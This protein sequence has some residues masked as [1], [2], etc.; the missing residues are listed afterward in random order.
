MQE[1]WFR[2]VKGLQTSRPRGY[3]VLKIV[4]WMLIAVIAL[5]GLGFSYSSPLAL[6]RS[7]EAP[8]IPAVGE[9]NSG[10]VKLTKTVDQKLTNTETH[11]VESET[12]TI[13]F[14]KICKERLSQLRSVGG[15]S[16][17][18]RKVLLDFIKR[19]EADRR[20]REEHEQVKQ[21]N[22]DSDDQ[23][24]EGSQTPQAKGDDDHNQIVV[25]E[26]RTSQTGGGVNIQIDDFKSRVSPLESDGDRLKEG[27]QLT[28]VGQGG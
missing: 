13:A 8:T 14:L 3:A 10:T 2:Y 15:L 1:V 26:T 4:A 28:Q 11:A 27:P 6:A 12:S 20:S 24:E 18:C 22:G 17:R 7:G 23:I 5:Y 9:V 25:E 19:R 16:S 21:N